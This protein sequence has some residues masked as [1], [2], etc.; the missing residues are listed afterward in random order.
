MK[1]TFDIDDR[2]DEIFRN[3]IAKRKGLHKGVIT[4]ALTEAIQDWVKKKK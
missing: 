2:L 1:I 3:T 4:D